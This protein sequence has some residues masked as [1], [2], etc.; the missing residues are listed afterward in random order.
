VKRRNGTG[1][2]R[3]F[4][5]TGLGGELLGCGVSSDVLRRAT[6]EQVQRASSGIKVGG[7]LMILFGAAFGLALFPYGL[8]VTFFCLVGADKIFSSANLA[9][10]IVDT[11]GCDDR[12]E[13]LMSKASCECCSGL[14]EQD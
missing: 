4:C 1:E 7:V 12:E 13:N 6:R 9:D 3:Q 10:E 2:E 11:T 8:I 14:K 5:R